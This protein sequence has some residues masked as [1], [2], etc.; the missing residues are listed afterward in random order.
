[1]RNSAAAELPPP[2]RGG[3]RVGP[4]DTR[5][6]V[7]AA[8]KRQFSELGYDRSSLRSIATEAGVDQK[9]VGYY[10]GSKQALFVAATQ[11][12][13]APGAAIPHVMDGP[14]TERGRR[15]ARLIVGMLEDPDSGPRLIGLVRAAAAE[16]EAARL[17]R[18]LFGR[19]IWGPAA[20][21]LPVRD[22]ELVVSLI[23][24]QVLGLV[25]S[26]HV[27]RAEPLASMPAE[28]VIDL[29]APVFQRLLAGDLEGGRHVRTHSAKR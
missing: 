18:D 12:P 27:V 7:L 23:A 28:A 4:S 2:A 14:V 26:R 29:T 1:M 10:F 25:M 17:A 15:L 21:N 8:A 3:R 24:M 11:L 22:P 16:P 5:S 13:F 6:A 9:L 19:E 20:A